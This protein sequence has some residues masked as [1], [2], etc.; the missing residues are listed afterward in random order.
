MKD[1]DSSQIQ[2]VS[3]S[4]QGKIPS[5]GVV[6]PGKWHTS[7]AFHSTNIWWQNTEGEEVKFW[8]LFILKCNKRT[9]VPC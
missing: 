5:F 6:K 4:L 7:S 8:R 2:S 9:E 1:K 3:V